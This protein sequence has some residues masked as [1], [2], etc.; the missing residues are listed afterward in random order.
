M[1]ALRPHPHVPVLWPFDDVW[2]TTGWVDSAKTT[3]QTEREAAS[4]SH[5][6]RGIMLLWSMQ[7]AMSLPKRTTTGL[8]Q[9]MLATL[10]DH[11]ARAEVA[12]W[13]TCLEAHQL[14]LDGDMPTARSLLVAMRARHEGQASA[15]S[16]AC[17]V[18][19]WYRLALLSCCP[20]THHTIAPPATAEVR[21]SRLYPLALQ[22]AMPTLQRLKDHRRA[23]PM[24]LRS[25]LA[26]I[27]VV[28]HAASPQTFTSEDWIHLLQDALRSPDDLQRAHASLS[29][30]LAY[31]AQGL[32]AR[33]QE[34]LLRAHEGA[35]Q[36]GWGQG[37]WISGVE[38]L[39]FHATPTGSH[40]PALFDGLQARLSAWLCDDASGEPI[41]MTDEH[42]AL[43][44]AQ[45]RVNKAIAFTGKNHELRLTVETLARHCHVSSRTLSQDFKDVLGLTPLEFL[46]RERMGRAR[47]ILEESALPLSEVAS[48]VGYDTVLGF[49]KAYIKVFGEAPRS[50]FTRSKP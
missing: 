40:S 30:G 50:S 10:K 5:A 22:A 13:L 33:A 46:T 45:K 1:I 20:V 43:S 15:L 12:D 21:T 17:E 39:P 27:A 41:E 2:P 6:Q 49:S 31:S 44:E 16:M 36:L 23:L 11:P 48:Q 7:E 47:Q 9:S 29:L 38:L 8:A 37:A 3:A 32:D 24:S 28:A 42:A 26:R 14:A 25:H 18:L 19:G 4:V 35:S 34:C